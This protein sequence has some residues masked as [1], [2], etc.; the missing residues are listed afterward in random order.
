M[1]YLML[2]L[3]CS[4]LTQPAISIFCYNS[5]MVIVFNLFDIK[6]FVSHFMHKLCINK[7]FIIIMTEYQ[8]VK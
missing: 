8:A 5:F 2:V 1:F 4:I 3:S 6:Y 7:V